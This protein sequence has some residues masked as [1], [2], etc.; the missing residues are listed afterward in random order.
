MDPLGPR[1]DR[2]E[3]RL[4]RRNREIVAV[5]F[6]EPDE[7]QAHLIG[8]HA[9]LDHVADHLGLGQERSALVDGNVA[10][11]VEAEFDA[12]AHLLVLSV[13]GNRVGLRTH[14]A[15]RRCFKSWPVNG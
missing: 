11:R 15:S 6:A 5:M 7:I 12:V 1:C 9:F 2:G 3:H 14:I 13:C 4:G 8:E 10:E